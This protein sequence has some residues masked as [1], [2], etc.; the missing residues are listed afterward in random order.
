M[1]RL[2]ALLLAAGMLTGVTG[3]AQAAPPAAKPTAKGPVGWDVYR[4]ADRLPEL[5]TGTQTKQFSSFD[6]TGGNNDGFEGTYSCLRTVTA[7]CV[8]AEHS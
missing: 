7:G 5:T 8:I 2:A 3:H 6:R 4:H 1:R